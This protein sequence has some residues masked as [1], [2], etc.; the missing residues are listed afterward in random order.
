[1][2]KLGRKGSVISYSFLVSETLA[3]EAASYNRK[4]NSEKANIE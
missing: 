1:M 4:R 3:A 2:T